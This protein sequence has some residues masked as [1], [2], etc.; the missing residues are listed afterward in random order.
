VVYT[1][2]TDPKSAGI[3]EARKNSTGLSNAPDYQ[4]F[5][6][7]VNKILPQL[8]TAGS[9]YN[10]QENNSVFAQQK[11]KQVAS[12]F[13][14]NY[15]SEVAK[16]QNEIGN[17]YQNIRNAG[18]QAILISDDNLM[19]NNCKLLVDLALNDSIPVFGTAVNNAEKGALASLSIN[20]NEL[21]LRTADV[22][23]SVIR[24]QNPDDIAIQYF[25]TEITAI[26][27]N[28][29]KQLGITLPETIL[30][31]ANYIFD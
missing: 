24:G 1:V 18:A 17:A 20:Y 13:Q 26:N 12:L 9:I 4:Q 19:A 21:C 3:L 28:T 10:Q 6:Q 15:I 8:E 5:F 16:Q 11:I 27:T 25:T 22:V 14:A 2:V 31:N 7:L 23:V 29:A 30:A